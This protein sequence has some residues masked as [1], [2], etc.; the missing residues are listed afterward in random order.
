MG[1]GRVLIPLLESG[2]TVDGVDYSPQMLV[3]CRHRCEERG[4]RPELYESNLQEL[5]LPH[6][7]EAIIVAGGSFL[8]IEKREESILALHRLFD[9]LEF[10]GRLLLDLF[11]PKPKF[12]SSELGRWGGSSTFH[13]PNKDIISMEGKCIEADLFFNQ[14]HVDY[15]KYEKWRDGVLIQ[16]ELQRF[17]LRW[18]GGEEFKYIL[19]SIGFTDVTVCADFEDGKNSDKW[20]SEI[21]LSS[22]ETIIMS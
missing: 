11:L 13:L 6:K 7:Y 1:S 18:Y 19:E 17:A 8:L 2:L 3:S 10:G 9:H 20:Q 12:N 5:S 21:R 16:T 15:L 4:L 22:G 14:Y